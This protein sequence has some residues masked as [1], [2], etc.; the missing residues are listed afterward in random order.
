MLPYVLSG[1]GVH[2]A[3][4]PVEYIPFEQR[5]QSELLFAPPPIVLPKRPARQS[6]QDVESLAPSLSPYLP[7]RHGTHESGLETPGNGLYFPA[8]H[9]VHSVA[10]PV[11]NVPVEQS[12]QALAF[13]Y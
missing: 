4:A 5:T 3:C 13:S 6:L 8:P 9:A 2:T 11:A 10:P 1:H 12:S 7:G